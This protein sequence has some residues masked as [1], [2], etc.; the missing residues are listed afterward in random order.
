LE[1]DINFLLDFISSEHG[2]DALTSAS[3][4]AWRELGLHVKRWGCGL[5]LGKPPNGFKWHLVCQKR[6][7]QVTERLK[8]GAT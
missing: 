1:F 3:S 5:Q 8:T 6:N 7:C 2:Q 4:L